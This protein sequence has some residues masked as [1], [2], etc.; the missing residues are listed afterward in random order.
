MEGLF[1]QVTTKDSRILTYIQNLEN[2]VDESWMI[3]MPE[4]FSEKGLYKELKQVVDLADQGKKVC[5]G[6]G[7][8]LRAFKE[9]PA[10]KARVIFVGQDPYY[11]PGVADG[12]AF[13][14]G[15]TNKEQP[16]LRFIFDEITRTI[17]S[18]SR[19]PDLVRWADQ[20][21]LLLNSAFT[22]D[23]GKPDSHTH[24]WEEFI[25]R[26]LHELGKLKNDSVFVFF[27]NR[28]KT[29]S[30]V[31]Q[32]EHKFQVI[33]PAAAAHRGGKWDCGD[34]FNKINEVLK[35]QGKKQ[36]LW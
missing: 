16:S 24:I 8:M 12:L 19:V 10:Y 26:F 13:S 9:T 1:D 15:L 33:H 36:I 17:G 21:V 7:L 29:Y 14:C 27:G 4:L 32:A 6:S 35:E 2:Y 28:A 18:C 34:I 25:S 20:G 5:P 3:S 22:V 31:V 11:T 23:A 30:Q